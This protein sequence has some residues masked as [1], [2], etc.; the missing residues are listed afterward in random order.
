MPQPTQPLIDQVLAQLLRQVELKLLGT[1]Y[2]IPKRKN[3]SKYYAKK[4]KYDG[5]TFDSKLEGA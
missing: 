4:V 5:I 1:D 3:K 2:L